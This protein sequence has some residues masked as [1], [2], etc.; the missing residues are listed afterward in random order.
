[1]AFSECTLF[2]AAVDGTKFKVCVDEATNAPLFEVM[3]SR[4]YYHEVV[5][6]NFVGA[7]P[8]AASF[9]LPE[10]C[11]PSSTGADVHVGG[12]ARAPSTPPQSLPV[13]GSSFPP[14]VPATHMR[15]YHAADYVPCAP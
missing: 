9:I 8:D 12:I 2:S 11:S 4:K 3:D 15:E 13:L 5:F 7:M 1:M 14:Y 10:K 6:Y